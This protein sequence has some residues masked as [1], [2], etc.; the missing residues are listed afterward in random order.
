MFSVQEAA[1]LKEVNHLDY[2]L[3]EF[4]QTL[5]RQLTAQALQRLSRT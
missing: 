5:A 1:F 3:Y 2:E 4:A